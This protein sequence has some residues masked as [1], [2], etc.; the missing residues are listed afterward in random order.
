MIDPTKEDIGR[1][2]AYTGN[3]F[4]GGEREYGHIT[5][6]NDHAVFV[7]YAGNR[8]SQATSREDLEFCQ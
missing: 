4:P 8:W 7:C 3:R 5:S 6:F 2:A 1:E